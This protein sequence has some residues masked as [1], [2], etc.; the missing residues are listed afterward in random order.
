[1]GISRRR[2]LWP[3]TVL[4][5]LAVLTVAFSINRTLLIDSKPQGVIV[6]IDG[7]AVGV[8]P[9]KTNL[10]FKNS[11]SIIHIEVA[12]EGHKPDPPEKNVSYRD[13][14]KTPRSGQ[15]PVEFQMVEIRRELQVGISA[16]VNGSSVF[17]DGKPAG[18]APLTTNLV[19]TRLA[20][21]SAWS[22]VS[23]RR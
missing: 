4:L 10:T 11:S 18:Q 6:L 3:P 20:E 1:M 13:V 12:K 21:T 7:R 17:V 2:N 22:T 9:L 8:T 5:G 19:F 23:C 16:S 15:F 14:E